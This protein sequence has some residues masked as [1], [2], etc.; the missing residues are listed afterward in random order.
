MADVARWLEDVARDPA[1]AGSPPSPEDLLATL[2]EDNPRLAGL[3]RYT[4]MVR[5]AEAVEDEAE[6]VEEPAAPS[7]DLT[8]IAAMLRSL[9]AEVEELRHRNDLLAAA[10]GGCHLCWGDD[11]LCETCAGRGRPGSALP[12]ARAFRACVLPAVRRV[13]ATRRAVARPSTTEGVP[14]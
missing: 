9:H 6:E 10:L 4:A 1:A 12:D 11:P 5:E 7:V 14:E 13:T 3:L 8:E 2:A